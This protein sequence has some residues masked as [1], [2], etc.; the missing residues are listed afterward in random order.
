M[1]AD[2][3]P[4]RRKGRESRPYRDFLEASTLGDIEIELRLNSQLTI[5]LRGIRY[6]DGYS[7]C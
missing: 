6:K 7:Q 1:D 2:P 3:I 5:V 4:S